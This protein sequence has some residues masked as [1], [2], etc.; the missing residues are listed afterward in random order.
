MATIEEYTGKQK[1]PKKEILQKLRKLIHKTL[2]KAGE[3]MKW[4]VPVFAKG[5]VYIVGLKDHVNMSFAV[6]GLSKE[7]TKGLEGSGK[8]MRHVKIHS[9]KDID[10]KKLARL[11]KLVDKKAECEC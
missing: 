10:E 1:S 5:K 3:E 4:G 6:K 9:M 8:T 7:E 11:L 2:P